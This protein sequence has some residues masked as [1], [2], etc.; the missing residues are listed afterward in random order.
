MKRIAF[1]GSI[2]L[3]PLGNPLI[4]KTGFGVSIPVLMLSVPERLNAET[5]KF[6]FNRAYDKGEKVI[7]TEQLRTS[8]KP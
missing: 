1:I 4:I 6:F 5:Y 8:Q 3:I 7:I 2:S